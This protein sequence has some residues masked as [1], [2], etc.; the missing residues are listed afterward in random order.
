MTLADMNKQREISAYSL[1]WEQAL[2]W[3]M[4][5]HRLVERAAPSDLLSVVSQICGLHAQLMSTAELSLWARIEGLGRDALQE[6]L[7]KHRTLVKLWAMRGTLHVLP[8]EELG[9]WVSAL[10]TYTNRGMTGHPKLDVL[11][12]AVGRALE[13]RVLTR[14]ELAL[15]VEKITGVRSLSKLVHESWGWPLKPASFRGRLCFAA[16]DRTRV[17]FTAPTTWI[18]DEINKRGWG[19][20]L[21]EVTRRFLAAYAPATIEDLARWWGVGPARG[22]RMLAAVGEEA[23]QVDVEGQPSWVLSRDMREM[24][25]AKSPNTARLLPAFDP[26]VIGTL[27]GKPTGSRCSEVLLGP[28]RRAQIFSPQGWVSPALLRPDRRRLESCARERTI[29]SEDRALRHVASLDG[30]AVPG[31]G[32]APRRVPRLQGSV[33]HQDESAS[34]TL[35][36]SFQFAP[37]FWQNSLSR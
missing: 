1:S 2:A 27:I 6:K 8:S 20:A 9:V 21:C 5:R 34:L 16:G 29:I 12:E 30:H 37:Q 14:E 13:G 19:D 18:R 22:K 28:G 3:R 4:K 31:R 15:A 26:W 32:G 17:R 11:T 7:W 36:T 23:V 35:F 24:A 10:S 25:S 33:V